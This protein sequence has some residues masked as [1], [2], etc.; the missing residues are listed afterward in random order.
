MIENLNE[1]VKV[2][3]ATDKSMLGLV[4]VGIMA[5]MGIGLGLITELV[6]RILGVKGG[7]H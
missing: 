4:T 3:Y 6:L 7:V 2:L 1:Y 5:G